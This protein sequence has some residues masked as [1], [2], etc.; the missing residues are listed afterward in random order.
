MMKRSISCAL[1]LSIGAAVNAAPA[2]VADVNSGSLEERVA[3]LERMV[4]ARKS[5]QMRIQ[6]HLDE[7][8]IEVD[9][10]RGEAEK[11]NNQMTRMLERQ[12]E[13]YL[14]LSKL[15]DKLSQAP[16]AG[17]SAATPTV[18]VNTPAVVPAG[19]EASAYDTAVNLILKEKRY[20]D[21]IPAF[22]A[23]LETYPSSSYAPNAHY[24]LGQ[25]LFNKQD[26]AGSA[27]Q[28]QAV[29]SNYPDSAKR[30]D[31]VLKLGMVEQKRG[32]L[33]RAQQLFQ[34]VIAEYPDSSARKLAESRLKAAN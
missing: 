30:A 8:Q 22:Q 24:W 1:L 32:N 10:L 34:Q 9:E 2:P 28:F 15:D 27:E 17:P 7:M 3:I 13:L 12:R 20:D 5:A 29:V 14:E 18:P 21:A 19:N 31:A 11:L 33:A 23:F 16:A 25:L 26:W 6:T 4:E